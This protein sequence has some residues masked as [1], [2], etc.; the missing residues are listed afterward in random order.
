MIMICTKAQAVRVHSKTCPT[1]RG[2]MLV[3]GA[4]EVLPLSPC[5]IMK[6]PYGAMRPAVLVCDVDVGHPLH[7]ALV[8]RALDLAE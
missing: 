1:W 7:I 5:C 8:S 3:L 4:E 2:R 6:F